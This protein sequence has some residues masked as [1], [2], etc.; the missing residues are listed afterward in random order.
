MADVHCI[1]SIQST[2]ILA[3]AIYCLPADALSNSFPNWSLC[4][5][6]CLPCTELLL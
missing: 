6:F 1:S 4:F 5:Y 3:E 2:T